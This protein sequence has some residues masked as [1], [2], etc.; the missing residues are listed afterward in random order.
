[1]KS[2]FS[3]KAIP[4][5]VTRAAHSPLVA[6]IYGGFVCLAYIGNPGSK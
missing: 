4:S 3:L 1:M 5:S 6:G 2:Y